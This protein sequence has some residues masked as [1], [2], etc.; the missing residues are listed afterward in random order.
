M[1]QDLIL[2]PAGL[3]T[4]PS[5]YS[6]APPGGLKAAENVV[7]RRAGI[8]EPRPGFSPSSPTSSYDLDL[9]WALIDYPGTGHLLHVGDPSPTNTTFINGAAVT[10]PDGTALEW[11]RGRIF[12]AAARKNLYL[13]TAD[14]VRKLTGTGASETAPRAG[15]PPPFLIIE[16]DTSTNGIVEQD[17]YYSYR[18]IKVRKDVNGVEVRSAPSNRV[19]YGNLDALQRSPIIRLFQHTNDDN[20]TDVEMWEI[21]RSFVSNTV[22]VPDEHF[23]LRSFGPKPSDT[24]FTEAFTDRTPDSELGGPLYTNDDE[25]GLENAN[26]RPPQANAIAEFNGSVV[27]GDLTFP[28][29]INLT[30]QYTDGLTAANAT[31]IGERDLTGTYTNG[32]AVVTGVAD[33]TG[34]KV[35]MIVIDTVGEWGSPATGEYTRVTA[36]TANSVTFSQVYT[37]ATGAK[38]RVVC[39]SIRVGARYFPVREQFEL[40]VVAFWNNFSN[41]GETYRA[42]TDVYALTEDVS[43]ALRDASLTWSG[44]TNRTLF[45]EAILPSSA[46]FVVYATHGDEYDPPLPEPTATGTTVEQETAPGGIMWSKAREPE[47]FSF[48]D[49]EQIGGEL[50]EV[51]RLLR[52]GDGLWIL[53]QD[54]VHR[55]S[56]ADRDSGFRFD[57]VSSVRLLHP[58]AACESGDR[59]FAWCDQGLMS[60]TSGMAEISSLAIA[61]RLRPIQNFKPQVANY[62]VWMAA[63]TKANELI[64]SRPVASDNYGSA[65]T[66]HVYNLETNAWV[67]WELLGDPTCAA[68]PDAG[69]QANQLIFGSVNSTFVTLTESAPISTSDAT[70]NYDGFLTPTCTVVGTVVT[71]T[72]AGGYVPRVGDLIVDGGGDSYFVT[73][74]ED[75]A[76]FTVDRAGLNV[77]SITAYNGYASTIT[78]IAQTAKNPSAIKLWGDGSLLFGRLENLYDLSIGFASSE[79]SGAT[80]ELGAV[81]D[82]PDGSGRSIRFIVPRTS[83]RTEQLFVTLNPEG[84]AQ[85]QWEGLSLSFKP[86]SLRTRS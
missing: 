35:G 78:V 54:G 74:V 67:E 33:T 73:A 6:A 75:S 68:V 41:A 50:A 60:L 12:G 55:M 27:L 13:T 4:N 63:N 84:V 29:S 16:D 39:D 8:V 20:D 56:G 34:F 44:P 59:A 65:P 85:W 26:Y 76:H 64:L 66:V 17:E 83:A 52:G 77:S 24:N 19:I 5:A 10:E 22:N 14:A 23:F 79:L 70:I 3:W 58:N 57:R 1:G 72:V 43:I 11:T 30:Y 21:Y 86:M 45:L 81:L 9:V 82:A 51:W 49:Y 69:A 18:A 32:S 38:T 7:I 53:K 48:I 46:P 71:I 47:H 25:E 62:G 15:T 40:G 36:K 42:S 80:F 31:G 2:R 37:G 61:N 28:A